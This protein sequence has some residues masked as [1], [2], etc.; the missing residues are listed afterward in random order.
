[1]REEL[2]STTEN[3]A[4]IGQRLAD[5]YEIL[6]LIGEGGIG[7]VYKARH[8]LMNRMVA[9]KII[10]SEMID[11]ST[12]IQRFQQEA[13][14]ISKLDH[15]NIV[16]VYDYGVAPDGLPYLV[17]DYLEGTTLADLLTAQG[18]MSPDRAMP[19]FLQACHALKHA[20]ENGIIHRDFKASN[21]V[22][23]QD[24]LLGEVVKVV[25]FGMAKLLHPDADNMNFQELT[26]SGEVFGS[27]LYMSPEQCKGLRLDERSDLYS[28]ACVMYYALAGRPPFLG[29]NVLGTLQMQINDSAVPPS[30][31]QAE[32]SPGLDSI[33]LKAL[34]KEP[35]NRYQQMNEML[36]DLEAVN[37]GQECV[38][39][40]QKLKIVEPPR[41]KVWTRNFESEIIFATVIGVAM[42]AMTAFMSG[43]MF[44]HEGETQEVNMWVDHN[45]DGDKALARHQYRTAERCY[46]EAITE[47]TKFGRNDPRLAKSLLSLARSYTEDRQ[48]TRAESSLKRAKQILEKCYGPGSFEESPVLFALAKVY[49]QQG[50]MDQAAETKHEAIRLMEP[51]V[52]KK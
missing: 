35:D 36:I 12:L 9:I 29:E 11:N 10:R 21:L 1:M 2:V 8:V 6:S 39:S 34:Q 52:G 46:Q 13:T 51:T 38:F 31:Y 7:L 33:V 48:Y 14:A 49:E 42:V 16:Q 50:L 17:M 24:P 25:D 4:L 3:D 44:E 20:H 47:A 32:I 27:P 15:P 23:C 43:R 41:K 30:N 45:L 26:Q 5:R 40:T 37:N 18:K 19:L 22:V 28:L